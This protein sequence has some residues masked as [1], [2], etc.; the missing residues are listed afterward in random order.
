MPLYCVIA[1]KMQLIVYTEYPSNLAY[2]NVGQIFH[3]KLWNQDETV[4]LHFALLDNQSIRKV[5]DA[6]ITLTITQS[7]WGP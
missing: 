7:N 5:I 4:S 1:T 3:P 6:L 2:Q